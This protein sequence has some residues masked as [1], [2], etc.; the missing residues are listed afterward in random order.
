VQPVTYQAR[1]VAGV[2]TD[3]IVLA[4]AIAELEDDH[5]RRRFVLAMCMLAS[6]KARSETP[7]DDRSAEHFARTLLMPEAAWRSAAGYSHAELAEAFNVPLDQVARRR[8]ELARAGWWQLA[9][10]AA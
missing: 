7:Y 5:P 8:A 6:D 1:L 2:G 10:E 4:P 9:P 3:E